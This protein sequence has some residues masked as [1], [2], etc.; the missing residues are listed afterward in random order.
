MSTTIEVPDD[1]LQRVVQASGGA[2]HRE[3]VLEALEEYAQ[4]HGQ[5]DLIQ[6]LGKLEGFPTQ[7]ELRQMRESE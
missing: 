2:T 3:A 6:Y 4:R 1:V 7:E 5:A